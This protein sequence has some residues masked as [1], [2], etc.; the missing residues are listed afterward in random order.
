MRLRSLVS[1]LSIAALV[2]LAAC[3]VPKYVPPRESP[4]L[5]HRSY[6][7]SHDRVWGALMETVRALE[8]PVE[9]SEKAS[10]AL[11]SGPLG[12]SF[13]EGVDCGEE[14]IEIDIERGIVT[15]HRR[16]WQSVVENP[17]LVIDHRLTALVREAEDGR[18]RVE[19]HVE[20]VGYRWNFGDSY[21]VRCE[22]TGAVEK[23]VFKAIEARLK[24]GEGAITRG[25]EAP[26]ELG[27]AP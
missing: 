12:S 26:R 4:S 17:G 23:A 21:E 22:S 25:S 7:G 13:L 20:M 3:A 2:A 8:I 19:L 24:E 10:G 27:V 5:R 11:R 16:A 6:D 18:T 1:S 15:D 9:E 14:R